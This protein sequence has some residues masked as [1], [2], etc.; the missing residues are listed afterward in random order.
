MASHAR[1]CISK[2]VFLDSP[3]QKI[4]CVFEMGNCASSVNCTMTDLPVES[5]PD[6]AGIGVLV[7]FGATAVITLT[8]IVI[9]YV[10]DSLPD[11][12]LTELD[13]AC[14]HFPIFQHLPFNY[15]QISDFEAPERGQPSFL[16]TPRDAAS[17]HD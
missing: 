11:S 5:D 17:C 1:P 10:T 14:K 15:Y 3:V 16:D 9:G 6:V 4:I 13:R 7:S 2:I 12:T 8:A